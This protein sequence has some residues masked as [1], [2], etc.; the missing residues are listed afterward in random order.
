MVTHLLE[1]ISGTA[2][3]TL[4]MKN[5]SQETNCRIADLHVLLINLHSV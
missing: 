3:V 2:G 1:Q 4:K 5:L